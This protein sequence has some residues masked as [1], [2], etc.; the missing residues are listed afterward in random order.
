[1][2]SCV[3]C[4]GDLAKGEGQVAACV[5][6]G[7][8]QAGHAERLAGCAAAQEVGRLHRAAADKLGQ[9]GHVAQVGHVGVVMPQH[10]TGKRLDFSEPR[11]LPAQRMPRY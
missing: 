1:M 11:R 7:A 3:D 8:A 2:S 6:Q 5:V 4:I 10:R 9:R